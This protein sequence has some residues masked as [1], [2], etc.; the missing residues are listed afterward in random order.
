MILGDLQIMGVRLC[1]T[2]ITKI[3]LADKVVW[4]VKQN[5]SDENPDGPVIPNLL[6][7]YHNG[8]WIDQYP[9]TD[10]TTWTD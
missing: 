4:V 10:D 3:Y 7:C 2:P 5:T 6:S 1:D 9:W 8:Y